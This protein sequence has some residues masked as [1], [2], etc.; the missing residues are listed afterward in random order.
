MDEPVISAARKIYNQ[1]V[2]LDANTA[3][4][5]LNVARTLLA[6]KQHAAVETLL[7]DGGRAS[8]SP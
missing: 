6:H 1:L 7:N 3:V 4:A 8:E 5:A 2:K